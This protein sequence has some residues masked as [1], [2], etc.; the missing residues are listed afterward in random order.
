MGV[1]K[2][3]NWRQSKP[4]LNGLPKKN[5]Q[6]EITHRKE[7]DIEDPKHQYS[8]STHERRQFFFNQEANDRRDHHSKHSIPIPKRIPFEF[9]RKRFSSQNLSQTL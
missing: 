8:Y 2:R 7:V 9:K 5:K 4:R 6:T 1:D 3:N